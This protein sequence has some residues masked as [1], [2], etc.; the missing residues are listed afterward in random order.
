MTRPLPPNYL[1]DFNRNPTRRLQISSQNCLLHP[2]HR[3]MTMM[4]LPL[5][6]SWLRPSLLF[7][8]SKF[9]H[10]VTT[11]EPRLLIGSIIAL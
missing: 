11:L 4:I 8:L 1:T 6:L 2:V 9:R 7:C 5:P 10:L 3:L